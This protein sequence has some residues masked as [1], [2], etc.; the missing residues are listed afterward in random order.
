MII[1]NRKK[2]HLLSTL[3]VLFTSLTMSVLLYKIV[4]L[5]QQF[6]K[7]CLM[8]IKHPQGSISKIINV[9]KYVNI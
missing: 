5:S 1:Q 9:A 7:S 8:D 2:Y 3:N 6:P 4:K